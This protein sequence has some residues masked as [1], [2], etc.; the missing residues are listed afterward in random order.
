MK[1]S[2]PRPR[3][4][5]GRLSH[6]PVSGHRGPVPA[7]RGGRRLPGRSTGGTRA[8]SASSRSPTSGRSAAR[9]SV[10]AGGQRQLV[11]AA[12]FCAW[13]VAACPPKPNGS[14]RRGAPRDASIR[15]ATSQPTNAAELR[16]AT[17]AIPRQSA[18]TRWATRRT[19]SATWLATCGSGARMGSREYTASA[20]VESARRAGGHPPGVPGRRLGVRR[21]GLPGG[22]P[23]AVE[24]EDRLRR[25][26]LSR[27][28]SSAQPVQVQQ[29]SQ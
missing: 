12:A 14:G 16:Q 29:R 8:D 11:E 18:S 1:A 7:V 3:S 19:G 17:S 4:L 28:R 20:A 23:P 15:G 13:A 21:R 25:P 26:G 22:V 2:A 5:P 6:R 27:G 24:P 10:A 9:L